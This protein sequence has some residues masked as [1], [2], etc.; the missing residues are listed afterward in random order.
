L[1]SRKQNTR[2]RKPD[3][4]RRRT[5][6][7]VLSESQLASLKAC[8]KLKNELE[9]AGAKNLKVYA[10]AWQQV[11]GHWGKRIIREEGSKVLCGHA[12]PHDLLEWLKDR[13]RKRGR[14]QW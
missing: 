2:S 1:K 4:S 10:G 3:A 12:A 9:S 11:I 8:E 14:R 13:T 7:Y 6:Q 5:W